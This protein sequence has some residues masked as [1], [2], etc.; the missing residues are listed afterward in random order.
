MIY[1]YLNGHEE[2]NSIQTAVQIFMPNEKYKPV[3]CVQNEGITVKSSI[4]AVSYTH[5]DVYKRQEFVCGLND[6]NL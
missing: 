6:K 5:L 2:M 3:E 4:N 1:I